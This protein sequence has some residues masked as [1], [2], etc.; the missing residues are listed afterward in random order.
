[1]NLKTNQL[2]LV[3]LA[4]FGLMS[5]LAQATP[6]ISSSSWD[7]DHKALECLFNGS[8]Y[9]DECTGASSG[10]ITS[11]DPLNPNEEYITS[12]AWMIGSSTASFAS[13][14]IEIAGHA[15]INTFGMYDLNNPN[16]RLEL[17]NG[18]QTTGAS[19]V[20]QYLGNGDYLFTN[21]SISLTQST[22]NLGGETFGWYLGAVGNIFYS[23]ASL[24]PNGSDQLVAFQGGDGRSANFFGKG[25]LP[26]LPNEWVLA[27][28]DLPYN[29]SDKDFNDF[30]VLVESVAPVP[31][32]EPGTLALLG[33]G[34]LYGAFRSRRRLQATLS[35]KSP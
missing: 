17:F 22:A 7:G 33:G 28:E 31:V 14:I 21:L 34:L 3:A 30:V 9:S 24:N 13:I 27:W 5:S 18:P 2:S 10:W 26:W 23:D 8:G 32:P 16:N 20:V 25:A 4:L 29:S 19:G 6:L 1:M 11:G 35:P 12:A 15:H